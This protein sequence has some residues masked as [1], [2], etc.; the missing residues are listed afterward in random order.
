MATNDYS[1]KVYTMESFTSQTTDANG[2][3]DLTLQNIPTAD[4]A[5]QLT[6]GTLGYFVEFISRADE[7]VTCRVRKLRYDKA[8]ATVTGNLTNLPS[9]VTE[10]SDST[11]TTSST[12]NADS[13]FNG[14]D[15][16]GAGGHTHTINKIFR[17]DHTITHTE[18]DIPIATN[19]GGITITVAYAFT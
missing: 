17:H 2:E 19:Q 8:D 18:V 3:I 16:V 13:G 6:I 9:G 14:S 4:D 15:P 12:G 5:L 10:T 1:G 7:V 11:I